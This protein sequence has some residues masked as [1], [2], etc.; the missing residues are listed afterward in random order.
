MTYNQLKKP[1]IRRPRVSSVAQKPHRSPVQRVRKTPT[2][3]V[4]QVPAGQ[5]ETPEDCPLG[6]W[7]FHGAEVLDLELKHVCLFL[8][9]LGHLLPDGLHEGRGGD[10]GQGRVR[11]VV[12]GQA[13]LR[14][15][16]GR[17]RGLLQAGVHTCGLAVLARESGGRVLLVTRPGVSLDV[18]WEGDLQRVLERREGPGLGRGSSHGTR[19]I[20][21]EGVGGGALKTRKEVRKKME[22]R[23][24]CTHREPGVCLF[25][26]QVI[27][28]RWICWVDERSRGFEPCYTQSLHLNLPGYL[29]NISTI[30]QTEVLF[31]TDL[32]GLRD[33]LPTGNC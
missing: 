33:S 21:G 18:P 10:V 9:Q 22:T 5:A 12:L 31:F 3:S 27:W 7:K 20:L 24:H 29:F 8:G 30:R 23:H 26:K 19:L 28:T 17:P 14:G 15:R 32:E 1:R 16:G 25:R 4:P 11:R 2:W 13:L 6:V